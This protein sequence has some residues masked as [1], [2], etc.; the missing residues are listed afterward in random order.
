MKIRVEPRFDVPR[1]MTALA[2]ISAVLVALLFGATLLAW[3][4]VSPIRAYTKMF[5][6]AFLEPYSLSDTT[7][8]AT[9]I[10]LAAL[11]VALAFRMKQWNIGAEGQL[12]IGAWA[13][14]G[15]ALHWLPKDTP[16]WLMLTAMSLAGFAAG[17]LW[18]TIPGLLK[19]YRGVNEIITTLM[20]NYIGIAYVSY[21]VYGPWSE[22]GFGLTPQF[23]RNA[24]LPRLADWAVQ[25]P[26]FRG[27]TL[28]AGIIYGFVAA[29][30]LY[31]ILTR[32]KWG[33]Q[34]RVIGENPNAARFA[35]MNVARN[36]LLAMIISGGLAGLAGMVEVAGVVHRLQERFSPGYG[37]TAIIV[38]WLGRLNP[39]GII[40]AAYMFGGLLVGGDNVQ[41]QGIPL[42]IQGVMLFCII[43]A[44]MLTRY[45]LSLERTP[46]GAPIREV[47][48]PSEVSSTSNPSTDQEQ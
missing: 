44:D 14:A 9:P 23:T 24:W 48:A 8:K 29:I 32:I 31:V 38:A 18:A 16:R 10:I 36:I 39:F 47:A 25:V 7:V 3:F 13:A 17:A 15:V 43:S 19:A 46:Q 27:L 5:Q 26:A 30:I 1:W 35:G 40:L 4:G 37:Y 12:F 34:L 41:P 33:Y 22:R 20:L 42:M 21:F 28:H 6:A 45:R 2:I 11:G